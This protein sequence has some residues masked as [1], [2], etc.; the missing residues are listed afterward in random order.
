MK[1]VKPRKT[2]GTDPGESSKADSMI[3]PDNLNP[4][5]PEWKWDGE[6]LEKVEEILGHHLQQKITQVGSEYPRAVGLFYLEGKT[7]PGFIAEF[8]CRLESITAGWVSDLKHLARLVGNRSFWLFPEFQIAES[9]ESAALSLSQGKTLLMFA[10]EQSF[11]IFPADFLSF[12]LKPGDPSGGWFSAGVAF[13]LGAFAVALFLPAFYI[14][15][16]SFQ[17]YA[18]SVKLFILLAEFRMKAPFP[19]VIEVLLLE[20]LIEALREGADKLA[21]PLGKLMGPIGGFLAAVGLAVSGLVNP[22]ASVF[23]S[24]ALMASL[25]FPTRDLLYP[26]RVIVLGS[27]IMTAIFGILGMVITASLVVAYLVCLSTAEWPYLQT[28]P[29]LKQS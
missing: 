8:S 13:R 25:V 10:G 2:N 16:I 22:V 24:A 27:I 15:M 26:M 18:V 7:R 29:G 3:A 28:G 12:F 9:P 11:L 5:E 6:S 14:A 19:P 21:S 20:A 1:P 17:Y 23:C 4:P